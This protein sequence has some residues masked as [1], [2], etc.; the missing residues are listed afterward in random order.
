VKRLSETRPLEDPEEHRLAELVRAA[1]RVGVSATK[2]PQI[3]A[4]VLAER[5]RHRGW[6][7][8]LRP[9]LVLGAL[10]L[11]GA[12]AA[13][14]L[15]PTWILARVKTLT[16]PAPVTTTRPSPQPSRVHHAALLEAPPTASATP[17]EDPAPVVAPTPVARAVVHP[18]G[19]PSGRENDRMPAS[20]HDDPTRLVDAIRAL[21]TDHDPARA[22]ALLAEYI[23]MYPHGA[24]AEE[25]LALSIEAADARNDPSTASFAE[26][27][28]KKY[29]R[30]RFR[31][32]A[33]QA[34]AQ[35]RR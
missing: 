31:R 21:R 17:A 8:G 15:G 7:F 27:Y 4:A 32:A 10:L 25:A 16:A 5:S 3:L 9:V 11:T 35:K 6:S 30:G 20:A 19:H 18:S 22:A 12:A 34:L 13:A 29:P 24:L 14:T 28:S 2:K 33:E 1:P 26:Q 23:K